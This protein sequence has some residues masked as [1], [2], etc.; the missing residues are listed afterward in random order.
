MLG[1]FITQMCLEKVIYLHKIK[2]LKLSLI[3]KPL[4]NLIKT[5]LMFQKLPFIN[6][7]INVLCQERSTH[8]HHPIQGKISWFHVLKNICACFLLE[9][10]FSLLLIFF[11]RT[12]RISK[13]HWYL[14]PIFLVH[15]HIILE[16]HFWNMLLEWKTCKLTFPKWQ[17]FQGKNK[18][19]LLSSLQNKYGEAFGCNDDLFFFTLFFWF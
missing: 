17:M 12:F 18:R 19:S 9:N 7:Q 16:F 14:K 13:C 10:C 15:F 6:M 2:L 3:A 1:F 11:I 5:K 8:Y 4:L